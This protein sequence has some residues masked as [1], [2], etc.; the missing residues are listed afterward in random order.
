MNDYCYLSTQDFLNIFPLW[1]MNHFSIFEKQFINRS[2]PAEINNNE[3]I[4]IKGLI[5]PVADNV[6]S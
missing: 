6:W 5:L 3:F 4:Y 1:F 2:A